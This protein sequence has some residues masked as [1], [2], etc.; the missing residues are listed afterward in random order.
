LASPSGGH[1]VTAVQWHPERM[2]ESDALAMALF[3]GLA[4]AARKSPVRA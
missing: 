3:R 1:W 2:V 4:A